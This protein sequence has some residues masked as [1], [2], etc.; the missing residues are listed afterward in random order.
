MPRACICHAWLHLAAGLRKGTLLRLH[1]CCRGTYSSAPGT[2]RASACAACSA[3]RAP[4]LVAPDAVPLP[5][6]AHVCRTCA[7]PAA[8]SRDGRP[9][10]GEG[11]DP[12]Q[13]AGA[14]GVGCAGAAP[15]DAVFRHRAGRAG[16]AGCRC[17]RARPSKRLRRG[18]PAGQGL[19]PSWGPACAPR[20]AGAAS[21]ALSTCAPRRAA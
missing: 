2:C 9:A 4:A 3:G 8:G 11:A 1:V 21:E 16:Q 7:G 14:A 12:H 20:P 5:P 10:G 18:C 19:P 17:L 6:P 13:G 15:L